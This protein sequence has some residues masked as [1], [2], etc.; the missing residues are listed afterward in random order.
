MLKVQNSATT[1]SASI[2]TMHKIYILNIVPSL[3][4]LEVH[5]QHH[6]QQ[7][8]K[9]TWIHIILVVH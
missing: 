8:L 1:D 2:I 9:K 5:L 7:D 3:A 6:E 4:A